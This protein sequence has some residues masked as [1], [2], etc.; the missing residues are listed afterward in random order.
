M[1]LL[2]SGRIRIIQSRVLGQFASSL[3]KINN[4]QDP[5]LTL[6]ELKA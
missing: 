5:N 4:K 3:G 6:N 2:I 1:L